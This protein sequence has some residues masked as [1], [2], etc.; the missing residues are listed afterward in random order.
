MKKDLVSLQIEYSWLKE[1]DSCLLRTSLDDLD[2]SY[3][4]FFKEHHGFPKFKVK[5]KRE[6]YRTIN[7]RSIY[8]GKEYVTIQIDLE[9]RTIK[10]PKLGEVSIRGYRNLE[11]FPQKILN[12]TIRKIAGKYYVSIC[13]EEIIE[14]LGHEMFATMV[15]DLE[16]TYSNDKERQFIQ[17][18][19]AALLK[20]E[21]I[22]YVT[23]IEEEIVGCGYT[24]NDY[25]DSLFVKDKFQNQGIGTELLKRMI[26][27]CENHII[28]LDARID[29]ISL[30]QGFGF[31]IKK[32]ND[33]GFTYQ[34]ELDRRKYGK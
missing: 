22:F 10:L 34:M 4:K 15:K 3:H 28:R 16:Y 5:G 12:A 29:A 18:L 14:F 8:K 6:S 25:F 20:E 24:K 17:F 27:D 32:K 2:T 9:N 21:V 13:V 23:K 31:T 33:S 30:Y 1:I 19:E 11:S 26:E 7:N